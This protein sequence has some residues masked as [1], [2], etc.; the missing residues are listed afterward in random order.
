MKE[1]EEDRKKR[2]G[3]VGGKAPSNV[4]TEGGITEIQND[5]GSTTF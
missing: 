4:K 5:D 1:N 3:K 2:L